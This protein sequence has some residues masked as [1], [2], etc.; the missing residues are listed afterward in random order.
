MQRL[1]DLNLPFA[2]LAVTACCEAANYNTVI[3]ISDC[4][5]TRFNIVKSQKVDSQVRLSRRLWL[6]DKRWIVSVL[7]I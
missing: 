4:H 2:Y 1:F 6:C 3:G 5:Q 7:K